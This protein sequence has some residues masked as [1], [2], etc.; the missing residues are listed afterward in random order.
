MG[1]NTQLNFGLVDLN[2]LGTISC[3][4]GLNAPSNCIAATSI[5]AN[6]NIP[7][8]KLQHRHQKQWANGLSTATAI[9]QQVVLHVVKGATATWIELKAA[10]V[11]K[12]VG[13]ATVTVDILKNGASIASPVIT[14]DNSVTNYTMVSMAAITGGGF[15]VGDVIE[16]K[17]VATAGGG[18]LPLGVFA[19]LV[20]DEDT[21]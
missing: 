15:L 14:L 6:A 16:L 3:G 5:K 19:Q 1:Q 18:T 4:Q 21:P 7:C 17:F 20:I 8:S 12:P 9:N 2:V 13:A 10:C 11:T